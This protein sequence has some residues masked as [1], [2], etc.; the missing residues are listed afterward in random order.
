MRSTHRDPIDHFR[1]TNHHAGEFFIDLY[2]W[3][4]LAS[5][6]LGAMSLVCCLAAAAYNHHEWVLTTA[7]VGALAIAGGIAWLVVEHHRVLRI[8]HQWMA[9]QNAAQPTSPLFVR[10]PQ[11]LGDE[12]ASQ[13]SND[14]IS[15]RNRVDWV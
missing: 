2:C 15:Q 8:E 12:M 7:V 6:A 9:A 10:L 11:N 13:Q 14:T 1:T 3:P 5:I 4:G